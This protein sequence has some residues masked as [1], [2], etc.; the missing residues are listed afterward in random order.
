[1]SR[2]IELIETIEPIGPMQPV[3]ATIYESTIFVC[4]VSTAISEWRMIYVK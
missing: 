2:K 1:M 3:N 4:I